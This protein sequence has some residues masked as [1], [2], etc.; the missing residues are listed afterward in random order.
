[1][2]QEHFPTRKYEEKN[3]FD[4]INRLQIAYELI[5]LTGLETQQ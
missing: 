1:M 3:I 2:R 5:P 4:R